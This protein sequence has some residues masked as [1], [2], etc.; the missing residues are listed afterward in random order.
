MCRR[1]IFG[2][3]M[4]KNDK[5]KSETGGMFS[6]FRL[7]LQEDLTFHEKWA[8]MLT[9]FQV[10]G[11]AGVA[12][13]L[14]MVF[15][16]V[17]FALTPLRAYVVPGYV[18]DDYRQQTAE[19]F[20]LAD[21]LQHRL[22]LQEQYLAHLNA[23]FRGEIVGSVP[24]DPTVSIDTVSIDS[25]LSTDALDAMRQRIQAEDAFVV[26][27]E[28]VPGETGQLLMPPLLGTVSAGFDLAGGHLGVDLVAPAGSGVHAV[29]PGVVLLAG[30][31]ALGGNTLVLQH[32]FGLVSIYQHNSRLNKSTGD[33]VSVGEIIGIIGNTGDH[34]SGPHLHF[35]LWEN[36]QV[37]DPAERIS[38]EGNQRPASP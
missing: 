26:S 32:A 8:L 3:A 17:L 27:A 24:F 2:A 33:V 11:L 19:T 28:G 21:S 22:D 15:S 25:S 35:E 6:K 12:G 29:A 1:V 16:Y 18:S 13:F 9:P 14:L 36:G 38:F 34:S 23:I 37:L 5:N 10:I 7:I 20:L 31:T 30:Y 4:A